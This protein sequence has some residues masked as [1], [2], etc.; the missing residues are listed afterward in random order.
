MGRHLG[1]SKA[2]KRGARQRRRAWTLCLDFND[3]DKLTEG[4]TG[5]IRIDGSTQ[6]SVGHRASPR[7]FVGRVLRSDVPPWTVNSGFHTTSSLSKKTP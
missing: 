2:A 5:R 7:L 6:P 4:Q 1:A 3:L